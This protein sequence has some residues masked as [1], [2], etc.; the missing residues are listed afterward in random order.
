ML[1]TLGSTS[2]IY[3]IILLGYVAGKL[4]AFS[5]M[6]LRALG[7]FVLTVA[8]PALLFTTLSQRPI[9]DLLHIS[10]LVAYT[11]GSLAVFFAGVTYARAVQRKSL[12]IAAL[13]GLG[14]S[15]SNSMLIAYPIAQLVVGPTA[16]VALAMCTVIENVLMQPLMLFIA[17]AGTASDE[18]RRHQFMQGLIKLV[19]NPFFLA[20]I[21]GALVSAL[22]LDLPD[23][24]LKVAGT[25]SA[26]TSAVSLFV[27]G[28]T[29]VGIEI[30]S[31]VGDVT[32]VVFGKLLLHPLAILAVAWA[33]P[34]MPRDLQLAAI[35]FG[36]VPML[37]IYPIWGQR[38]GQEQFCAAA[39]LMTTVV[40]FFTVSVLLL[41]VN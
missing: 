5:P 40:S 19:R 2:A 9:G 30:K 23:P 37:S 28:G 16:A 24:L 1:S 7:K 31:M 32:R 36:A 3:A 12:P 39:L 11:F 35:V 34:P 29:L 22:A 14:M 33:M 27:I 38:F 13:S 18:G 4:G 8:I 21:A 20:I 25:L 41:V 26:A 17:E 6:E 15:S 10:F